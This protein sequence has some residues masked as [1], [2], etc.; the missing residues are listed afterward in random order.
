MRTLLLLTCILIT[1][2]LPAQQRQWTEE[3]KEAAI[4]RHRSYQASLNLSEEQKPLV[5]ET[6]AEYM[7][8]L[9]DIKKSEASRLEKLRAF[10]K[11]NAARDKKMKEILDKEQYDI[12]K[13]HQ[14]E[15]KEEFRERRRDER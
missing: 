2:N 13:K 10:R 12:Y 3:E 9:A 5:E 4:E 8:A 11:A 15:M 14:E 6:S 7:T 1:T